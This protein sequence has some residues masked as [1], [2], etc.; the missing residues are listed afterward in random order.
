VM[1]WYAD[2]VAPPNVVLE[3]L[4]VFKVKPDVGWVGGAMHRRKGW[5]P[6]RG[7]GGP[8]SDHEPPLNVAFP[9]PLDLVDSKEIVQAEYTG[10][11]WMCPKTPL[12][13]TKFYDHRIR[14]Q[15]MSLILNL[16]KQGL[17]VYYQPTVYLK[18]VSTDGVI[19]NHSLEGGP[20]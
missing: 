19:Y 13:K 15:H 18:H 9:V 1:P 12:A 7:I 2:V 17:K 4:T 10:H 14:D 8:I 20:C 5:P 3:Y 16:E 6:V 11:C